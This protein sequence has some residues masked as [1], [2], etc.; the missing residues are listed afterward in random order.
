MV[1]KNIYRIGCLDLGSNAIKYKQ[2]RIKQDNEKFYE[3]LE[4]YKRI[5]IRL[6]TDAFKKR[7]IKKKTAQKL[8]EE[9]ETLALQLNLKKV[10]LIG[11]YATSAMRTASNGEEICQYI[12]QNLDIEL[13]ILSGEDEAKLLS[14]LTKKYPQ[15]GTHLFV[16]VG[17]GSTEIY[18]ENGESKQI[19]SFNLGAV[20]VYLEE[21]NLSDWKD[22]EDYLS[23]LKDSPVR[24]IIGVGGNIRS[25][26]SIINKNQN[27]SISIDQL[28][29]CM[30]KLA[31]YGKKEKMKIYS[32]SKDRADIIESA[33]K[34]FIRIMSLVPNSTL[35]SASWSICDAL[36]RNFINE[37]H[38]GLSSEL[39]KTSS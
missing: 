6:G 29:A 7:K 9:L 8:V 4:A 39:N 16:D 15:N 13:T 20:R 14:H 38:A 12:K 32:L 10:N 23:K 28:E 31:K 26:I 18:Y 19:Q 34:I 27:L 21:E 11:G 3:E 33:A 17:G 5:P 24:K 2:Y 25:L 35:Q 30:S 1:N 37:N 36:V 22:L